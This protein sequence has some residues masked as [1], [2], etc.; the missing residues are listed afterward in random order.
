MIFS[1]VSHESEAQLKRKVYEEVIIL[2][3]SL[4]G[5]QHEGGGF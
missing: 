3:T 4:V 5:T 1:L 2:E